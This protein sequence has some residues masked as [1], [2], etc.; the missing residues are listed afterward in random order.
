MGLL[1]DVVPN[2]MCIASSENRYWQ[3]VLENARSSPWARLFDI[4]WHP[5]KAELNDKVLLPVLGD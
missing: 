2:H 3:D 4:D 5:P 1:M